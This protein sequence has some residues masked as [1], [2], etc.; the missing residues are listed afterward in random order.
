MITPLDS[1]QWDNILWDSLPW[2]SL[3]TLSG[4]VHS[5]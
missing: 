3:L 5:G 4:I 2:D 1:A